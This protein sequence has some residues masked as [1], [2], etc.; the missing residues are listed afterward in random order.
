[1]N[2]RLFEAAC[3]GSVEVL[4]EVLLDLLSWKDLKDRDERTPIHLAAMKGRLDVMGELLSPSVSLVGETVE[5][6]LNIKSERIVEVNA[7]NL[8]NLTAMDQSS[9]DEGI[10]PWTFVQQLGEA[11]F[12]PAGC[13]HQVQILRLH[14]EQKEVIVVPLS[15]IGKGKLWP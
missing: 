7:K 13:P 5:L 12:I 6:L 8:N 1:M 10:E 4:L 15:L 14:L 2:R 9:C 11:V 3:L